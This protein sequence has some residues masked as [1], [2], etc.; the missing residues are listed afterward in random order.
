MRGE[1]KKKGKEMLV[2]MDYTIYIYGE[3]DNKQY[4]CQS[5]PF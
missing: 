1:E 2:D 5:D 4:S 3:N